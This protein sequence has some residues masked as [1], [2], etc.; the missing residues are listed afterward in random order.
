MKTQ[1]MESPASGVGLDRITIKGSQNREP[2]PFAANRI[3]KCLGAL[4][5]NF[6]LRQQSGAEPAL[7]IPSSSLTLRT[8]ELMKGE[9]ENT[10]EKRKVPEMKR[11]TC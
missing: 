7:K 6:L 5:S 9:D 1:G 8:S 3:S 4:A 2:V 11:V 10:D